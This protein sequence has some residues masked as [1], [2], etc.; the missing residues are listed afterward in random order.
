MLL[1]KF[2]SCRTSAFVIAERIALALLKTDPRQALETVVL[3]QRVEQR[4]G[5]LHSPAVGSA[6]NND[7][8][9]EGGAVAEIELVIVRVSQ[10]D[11]SLQQLQ[12]AK[13]RQ[14]TDLAVARVRWQHGQPVK[15]A[16]ELGPGSLRVAR[17]IL[18]KIYI[19]LVNRFQFRYASSGASF[20]AAIYAAY[21]SYMRQRTSVA[22]TDE[23]QDAA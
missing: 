1:Q 23:D 17:H 10:Q 12:N 19:I 13:G 18:H 15:R 16:Q 7:V 21:V 6:V 11:P 2:L 5:T 9:A 20:A 22:V 4:D 3:E 14:L 8:L